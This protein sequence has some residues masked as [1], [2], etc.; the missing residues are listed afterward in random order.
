MQ[1]AITWNSV[2]LSSK[3]F[4]AIHLRVISQEVLMNICNTHSDMML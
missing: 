2:P 3:V 4:C 1:Q